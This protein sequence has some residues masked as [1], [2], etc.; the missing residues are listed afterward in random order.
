MEQN[1][2]PNLLVILSINS[3]KFPDSCKIA[4]IKPLYKKVFLNKPWN[5]RSISLLPLS[6]KKGY[7]Q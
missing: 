1:F 3:E 2:Y 7:S 4:K 6:H 5:G